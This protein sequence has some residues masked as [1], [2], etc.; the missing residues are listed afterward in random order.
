MRGLRGYFGGSW[1]RLRG[2][3]RGWQTRKDIVSPVMVNLIT[4]LILFVLV[5]AFKERVLR[6]LGV[7]K[8]VEG[9]PIYCVAEPF[10]VPSQ[11][12]S[13]SFEVHADLFI[14]NL[15]ARTFSD[16]T[17]F[18]LELRKIVGSE[19]A[20][21]RGSTITLRWKDGIPGAI[22]TIDADEAFNARKGEAIAHELPDGTWEVTVNWIKERG[23]LRLRVLTSWP[24]PGI[25]RAS[26]GSLP[27]TIE[28]PGRR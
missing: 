20:L 28:Y 9:Y 24:V 21:R 12:N 23:I 7:W 25:S 17:A 11:S 10:S 15:E 19:D 3:C 6:A 27:F 26:R 22:K 1:K 8:G 14:I 13:G 16:P 18:A 2:Y 5:V 4:A